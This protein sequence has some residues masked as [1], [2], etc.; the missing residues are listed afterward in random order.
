MII[1]VSGREEMAARGQDDGDF[2]LDLPLNKIDFILPLYVEKPF[3]TALI[4]AFA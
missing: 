1:H 3:A 2:L 4:I